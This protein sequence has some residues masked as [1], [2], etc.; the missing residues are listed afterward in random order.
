MPTDAGRAPPVDGDQ[1][2]YEPVKL[3]GSGGMGEVVLAHDH[4]IARRVAVKRLNTET[5]DPSIFARFVDEIR[6]VGRLEHPNIVPIHDVGI[7][8]LGRYYF[9][10]KYVAGETLQS[11]IGKLRAGDASYHRTYS[12]E[13]RIQVVL[14]LLNALAYAHDHGVLHRDVKPANVMIGNFG[15]V[16]LM[17]WG[18]AKPMASKEGGGAVAGGGIPDSVTDRTS[19]TRFGSLIGTPAYMSPEQARGENDS[20]DARS[21]LYGVTVLFHELMSL[22]HYLDAKSSAQSTLAAVVGERFGFVRAMFHVHPNQPRLPGEIAHFVVRGL[23][24]A[25]EDRFQSAG[26]MIAEL[27]RILEGRVRVEC[28]ITL[29]K[30]GFRELGRFLDRSPSFAVLALLGIVGAVLFTGITLIRSV[31]G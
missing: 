7:D 8:E 12:C 20:L 16:V 17:D 29:T 28:P 24:K 13:R 10:M 1:P 5:S 27:E 22:R 9:V 15:E 26:E 4:D 11:V 30:R 31:V 6:T 3:L 18:V 2:R 19:S 25:K 21:D 23:A 14:A